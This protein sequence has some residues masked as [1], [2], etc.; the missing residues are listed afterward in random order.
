MCSLTRCF[1][2]AWLERMWGNTREIQLFFKLLRRRRPRAESSFL[3]ETAL[4][5]F[6]FREIYIKNG[7]QKYA[8]IGA[9]ARFQLAAEADEKSY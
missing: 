9:E 5:R 2:F 4:I 7:I 3:H 8:C 1:R 6:K